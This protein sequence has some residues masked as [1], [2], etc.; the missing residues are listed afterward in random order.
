MTY[1]ARTLTYPIEIARIAFIES[2]NQSVVELFSVAPQ[3][4][5]SIF[6]YNSKQFFCWPDLVS[7]DVYNT[8][9][10]SKYG[11]IKY[12]TKWFSRPNE[13]AVDISNKF[14]QHKKRRNQ[15]YFC[16][17]NLNCVLILNCTV[18]L[19]LSLIISILLIKSG[20][21]LF[22]L[23]AHAHSKWVTVVDHLNCQAIFCSVLTSQIVEHIFCTKSLCWC[24]YSF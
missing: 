3:T 5:H 18:L 4:H 12:R 8:S 20:R 7:V 2:S 10:S 24:F 21:L 16:E 14:Q 19:D 22:W 15:T 9:V 23:W 6:V 13:N 17:L 11:P 1:L